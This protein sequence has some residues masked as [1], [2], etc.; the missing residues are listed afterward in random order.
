MKR[1]VY[2]QNLFLR[3]AIGSFLVLIC[4]LLC[5]NLREPRHSEYWTQ[6]GL[7]WYSSGCWT[8]KIHIHQETSF[9]FIIFHIRLHLPLG[10]SFISLHS[11]RWGWCYREMTFCQHWQNTVKNIRFHQGPYKQVT[12]LIKWESSINVIYC[13]LITERSTI[14][15][16]PNEDNAMTNE[17][18][19]RC[20]EDFPL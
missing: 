6:V 20:C 5:K 7:S 14:L 2:S 8:R 16:S 18:T 17:R 3:Q 10:T 4:I 9:F 19:S 15:W 12:K 11:R 13:I 1:R